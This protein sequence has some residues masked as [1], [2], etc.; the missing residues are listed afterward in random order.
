MA[1]SEIQE[2]NLYSYYNGIKA[3]VVNDAHRV[4]TATFKDPKGTRREYPNRVKINGREAKR[5]YINKNNR[6]YLIYEKSYIT[7]KFFQILN[8]VG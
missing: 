4:V 8:T 7:D 1:N 6:N 5:W 2:R 3:G